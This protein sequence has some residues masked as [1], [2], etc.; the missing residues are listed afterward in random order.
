M[1]ATREAEIFITPTEA[2]AIYLG[3]IPPSL[4]KSSM[5]MVMRISAIC[6]NSVELQC[7][8]PRT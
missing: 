3:I 6:L 8:N 2:L 4:T 7:E 1:M 5:E